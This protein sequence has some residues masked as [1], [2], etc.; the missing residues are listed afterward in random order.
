MLV[1]YDDGTHFQDAE[2]VTVAQKSMS[3][4]KLSLYENDIYFMEYKPG[5]LLN[6]IYNYVC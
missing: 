4:R 1:L 5:C 6:E 2:S 3:H